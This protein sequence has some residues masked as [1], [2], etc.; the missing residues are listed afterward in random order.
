[1]KGFGPREQGD[2]DTSFGTDGVFELKID[3]YIVDPGA[4]ERLRAMARTA[5]GKIML[6]MGCRIEFQGWQYGLARLTPTGQFD[7]SF[8]S[9]G[10]V[11]EPP[12]PEETLQG[13][14]PLPMVGGTTVLVLRSQ[15]SDTWMI[16]RRNASG[17]LDATFG[18][19]GYVNLDGIRQATEPG[20]VKGFAIPA[21]DD[22]FFFVGTTKN[23]ELK[24]GG[25]VFRFDA[26]GKLN[27]AFAGNGYALVDLALGQS[28]R[29]TDAVL[30]SDGKIVLSTA[31]LPGN[32]QIVR[33]LPSGALDPTYGNAGRVVIDGD[34]LSDRTE[35]EKLAWWS[36]GL[37]AAG[38]YASR[39]ARTG[40]LV[41]LDDNGDI[42]AAFNDGKPVQIRYGENDNDG[43]RL[44]YPMHIEA[45]ADGGVT[46]LGSAD[47]DRTEVKRVIVGR[48]LSSGTLDHSFGSPDATGTRKGFYA[49]DFKREA[50]NFIFVGVDVS[51]D[52][53]TFEILS[54]DGMGGS[55]PDRVTVERFFAS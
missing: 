46:V 41:A 4:S 15:G 5:D 55:N 35:V 40:L 47:H 1:M 14:Q 10:V 3:G 16:T 42:P 51:K 32:A 17:E 45:A 54:G 9:Q 30:Q 19:N 26:S 23:A 38:T 31:S 37:W 33:L 7:P 53:L 27:P 39:N 43:G 48:H 34:G 11:I 2:I 22:G 13:A 52:H 36:G 18:I 12:L 8:G 29:V 24:Y 20:V 50:F 21:A 28:G 25:I 44:A 6:A 49:I